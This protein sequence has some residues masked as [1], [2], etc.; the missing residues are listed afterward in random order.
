MVGCFL[1]V[2]FLV[3]GVFLVVV[4]VLVFFFVVLV[5]LVGVFFF[6][7]LGAGGGGGGVLDSLVSKFVCLV[8]VC[9]K[10]VVILDFFVLIYF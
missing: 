9:L 2:V 6:L 3:V 5:V 8:V 7:G 4:V 1:E 10:W